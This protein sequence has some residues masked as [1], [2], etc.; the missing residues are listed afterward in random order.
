MVG[1]SKK[2]HIYYLLAYSLYILIYIFSYNLPFIVYIHITSI[3]IGI[4][5]VYRYIAKANNNLNTH[6]YKL[7]FRILILN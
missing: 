1:K 2:S 5:K 6:T 3:Y 4:Y 7:H